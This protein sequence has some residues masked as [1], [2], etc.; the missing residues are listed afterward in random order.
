MN[1][2]E[3][4]KNVINDMRNIKKEYATIQQLILAEQLHRWKKQYTE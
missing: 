4:I 3:K 2:K 1:I